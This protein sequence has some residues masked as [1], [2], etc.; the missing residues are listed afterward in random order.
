MLHK[1]PLPPSYLLLAC[2]AMVLL[3]LLAPLSVVIAMPWRLLGV[4]PLLLGIVLNLHAD[5]ALRR[6]HTTVKPFAASAV[7]VTD[8]VYRISR[9]PM[10]LGMALILL[11]LAI[12]MGSLTPFLVVPAFVLLMEWRFIRR[13]EAMLAERFGADWQRYRS[14]TPRWL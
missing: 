7:L 4:L 8:G 10:Y 14:R 9:H 12:F 3:H 11:G 13:E 1:A 6:H 2:V 5:G